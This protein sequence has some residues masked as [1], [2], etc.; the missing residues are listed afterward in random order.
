MYS[1]CLEQLNLQ[2]GQSFLDI[3]SGCGHFTALGG[4]LVGKYGISHG[5]EL[6]DDIVKL[7]EKNVRN[8]MENSNMDLRNVKFFVRNCFLPQMR[9]YGKKFR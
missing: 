1:T 2:S 4:Y 3:G 8:F 9:T 5:L 7:S 6:R